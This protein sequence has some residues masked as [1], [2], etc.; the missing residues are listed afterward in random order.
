MDDDESGFEVELLD[1]EEVESNQDGTAA[2]PASLLQIEQRAAAASISVEWRSYDWTRDA[3]SGVAKDVEWVLIV[4]LP[5]GGKDQRRFSVSAR[6]AEEWLAS[7]FDNWIFL[8]DYGAVFDR[9]KNFIEALVRAPR[10]SLSNIIHSLH[11]QA[12]R[13]S[14]TDFLQAVPSENTMKISCNGNALVVD[15]ELSPVSPGLGAAE[16]SSSS[17]S[18]KLALNA[19]VTYEAAVSLLERF[20]AALFFELDML[21]DAPLSLRESKAQRLRSTMRHRIPDNLRMPTSPKNSYPAEATSLYTYGR[22]ANDMPLLQYLAFYQVLEYF[23]PIYSRS[24]TVRRFQRRL[25]DPVFDPNNESQIAT[26]VSFLNSEA[27]AL[28]YEEEQ[29][30]AT[31]DAC[32]DDDSIRRFFDQFEG[33]RDFLA[34]KN[35][36][37]GVSHLVFTEHGNVPPLVNQ[38]AARIYQ[39][40]CR[41]V[42]AK[43]DGGP[44]GVEILLP[45]SAEAKMLRHDIDFVR[46]IAQ[47]VLIQGASRSSW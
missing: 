27:R 24:E 41:I 40:R 1:S 30:K 38:V 46:W 34:K 6:S 2:K 17:M 4:S 5:S 15:A 14:M 31:L 12:T 10:L 23:F 21:Y 13:K 26:L 19:P 42:H 18:L 37:K 16:G 33:C 29:L 45:Y 3:L 25:K 39:I 8:K 7:N 47:R 44:R 11:R 20:S 43:E 22:S 35:A 28:Q 9:S 32:I 36:L